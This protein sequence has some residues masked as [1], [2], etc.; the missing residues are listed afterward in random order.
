MDSGTLLVGLAGPAA[1]VVGE[2][3]AGGGPAG[4]RGPDLG[5]RALMA[6]TEGVYRPVFGGVGPF[7]LRE[8]G[9][10][11]E[12][13]RGRER[14]EK[15]RVRALPSFFSFLSLLTRARAPSSFLLPALFRLR[16]R[17]PQVR[18]QRPGHLQGAVG[19]PHVSGRGV[20]REGA[21]KKNGQSA[22]FRAAGGVGPTPPLFF[23]CSRPPLPVPFPG[24]SCGT[25][26]PPAWPS[27]ATRPGRR[28]T[29]RAAPTPAS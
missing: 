13:K 2:G 14:R 26:P 4:G 5:P 6:W 3:G 9:E 15:K 11:E 22:G 29:G 17:R 18:G 28:R 16:L 10:R 24:P 27:C 25:T 20:L 12:K 8:N 23:F 19:A 21:I 1:A 7:A